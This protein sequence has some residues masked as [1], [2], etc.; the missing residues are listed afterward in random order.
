MR[1][2]IIKKILD[3]AD[4]LLDVHNTFNEVSGAFLI[5]EEQKLAKYFPVKKFVM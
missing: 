3:T 1:A 5:G 4:C 2:R